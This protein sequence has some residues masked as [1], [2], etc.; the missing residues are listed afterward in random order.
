MFVH[1][2]SH[3]YDSDL[4]ELDKNNLIKKI[5]PYPHKKSGYRQNLVNA[6][7]YAI[8]K[9]CLDKKLDG[10]ECS[11]F[12]KDFFPHLLENQGKIIGYKSQEYIKDIG[13]PERLDSVIKDIVKPPI[14][15]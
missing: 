7:L 5:H 11:D 6:A 14:L 8:N 1:P 3:P 10:N 15:R 12:A 4:I 13:T 9:K 2:N